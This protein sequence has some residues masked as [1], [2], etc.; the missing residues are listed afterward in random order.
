MKGNTSLDSLPSLYAKLLSELAGL[1]TSVPQAL[2]MIHEE[3]ATVTNKLFFLSLRIDSAYRWVVT[4]Y[5][6]N[7]SLS[8]GVSCVFCAQFRVDGIKTKQNPLGS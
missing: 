7:R 4:S 1:Y 3:I 8:A 6:R 5:K 2:R